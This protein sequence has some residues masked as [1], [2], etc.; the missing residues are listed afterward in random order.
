M[1]EICW[2]ACDQCGTCI[3]VCPADA[4]RLAERLKVDHEACVRCGICVRI[5]PFGALTLGD[6][7][8]TKP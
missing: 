7:R 6:E 2:P 8:N 4:L 3:S 5:C 1:L